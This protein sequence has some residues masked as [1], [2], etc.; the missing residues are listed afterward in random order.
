[1]KTIPAGQFKTHCL[2]LLDEVARSRLPILVTKHGK[3]VATIHP[4]AP[5]PGTSRNPLKG[6]IVSETDIVSR[7]GEAWEADR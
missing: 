7:L 5:A 2:S 1:M 4:L 3:P 6:S